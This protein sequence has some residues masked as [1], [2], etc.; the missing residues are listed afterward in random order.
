MIGAR[1][2]RES[3]EKHAHLYPPVPPNTGMPHWRIT[4]GLLNQVRPPIAIGRGANLPAMVG[5]GDLP[6]LSWKERLI[7][8]LVSTLTTGNCRTGAHLAGRSLG[9]LS[10][11]TWS[12]SVD[13]QSRHSAVESRQGEMEQSTFLFLMWTW[14]L[15]RRPG[16]GVAASWCTMRTAN[17]AIEATLLMGWSMRANSRSPN[18][19]KITGGVRRET[20]KGQDTGDLPH[21]HTLWARKRLETAGKTQVTKWWG[22]YTCAWGWTFD[23][24]ILL[25]ETGVFFWRHLISNISLQ[26]VP[27]ESCL[28]FSSI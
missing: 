20:A 26:C 5:L 15:S 19:R 9:D 8:V 4:V 7:V 18:P 14:R 6:A 3:T 13:S 12:Q 1:T 17:P 24:P 23:C 10:V 2:D 21:P 22:R 16:V 27:G 11:S 28:G 25:S